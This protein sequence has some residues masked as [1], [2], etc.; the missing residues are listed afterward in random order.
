[1]YPEP[2]AV[3]QTRGCSAANLMV[4]YL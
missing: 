2:C 1:M 4:G 3:A